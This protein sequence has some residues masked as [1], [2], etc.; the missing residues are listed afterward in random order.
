LIA[1][2]AHA[3]LHACFAVESFL[4]AA[5]RRLS[6]EG[7]GTPGA[8]VLTEG[9]GERAME[10]LEGLGARTAWGVEPL[11]AGAVLRLRRRGSG[12][13]VLAVRGRQLRTR[14]NLEVLAV[15]GAVET[16]SDGSSV[17]ATVRAVQA[18]G[19]VPVI[20]WGFG[21]WW[22]SRA[23]VVLRCIERT[24]PSLLFLGDSGGRMAGSPRPRLLDLAR[25]RGVRVL[26]GSDPL[27]FAREGTRAGS[28]GSILSVGLDPDRPASSLVEALRD[29]TLE[30]R[31]FG[32]GVSPGRF[33]LNQVRMLWRARG[34]P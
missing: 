7:S 29:P 11:E 18:A 17:G 22:G 24:D 10:A 13:Q 28:F 16:L 31:S 1:V 3:H 23:A 27:P 14:E 30:P 25:H 34:R 2:D 9:R 4:L 33:L 5:A 6:K 26:S 15:G 20:P 21:K 19:G 12:D 32:R 8:L